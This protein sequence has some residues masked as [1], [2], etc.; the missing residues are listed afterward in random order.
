MKQNKK[1]TMLLIF[2]FGIGLNHLYS[3]EYFEL[4][5]N[6]TENTTLQEIQELAETYFTNR[7]K[8]RGSGYKQYKRWEYKMERYVNAD[9]KIQNFSRLNWDV[10]TKLNSENP[11]VRIAAGDWTNLGPSSYT[12]GSSGYNGGLGRVNVIAFHPTDS[13]IIYVGV[14][15]GGLWKTTDGGTSWSPMSDV[16]ASLGVSGI[17]VDHTTPSTVY[18]LTGDGDGG[19]TKSIGVMKSTDGGGTWTSTGLSWSVTS[20]HKGYKLLMHPTTSSTMFAATTIGLLKTT[21]SWATWTTEISGSFRDIEFKPGD[22]TT[23]Y[24]C[25]K[26]TFYRSTDTGATW[27]LISSGLPTGES[28]AALA[29]SPA[30]SGYVYYLAGPGG[31]SG[32]ST[33]KGMYLSTDSGLTF[34]TKSTTPNILGYDSAGGG[35]SDQSWYDLAIAVNPLDKDNT[36]TGGINIWRSTDGGASNTMIAHW[37]SPTA[38]QYVHADIHELVYNPLDDILYSGSDGGISKSTDNGVTWTNIWDGLEIMQ[39]YRIVGVEDD[40]DLLIGG[41]QD[42]GSNKY[43]GSTTIEHILGGDGMDCMINYLDHD[44]IY[45]SFQLGGLQ[46]STDGG[47]SSTGIQPSGSTGAW[48]TPYAMDASDPTIIYGGYDDVYRSTNMGTSWSNLGSDGSGALAVGIDDPARI[49]AATGSTIATSAD[50]GG[51]WS[52]ITGTWPALTITFIALDPAD[53]KRIWITLGGYTSG[54]KV[55]E[56][57]DAGVSWTNV[58]G[59]LPN[60]PALSIAY[61]DTGGTPMDAMYVGMGVGIYYKSDSTAWTLYNT[62]LPNVPIYDLQINYDNC[63]I[64][65]GTFGRG[66]WE[67]LLYGSVLISD[68]TSTDPSCPGTS[69]ATITVTASCTTCSGISYT[70]TPT[71][72]PGTPITQIGDGVFL[73]LPSNDYDVSVVDTGVASCVNSWASNPIVIAPG[74][75]TTPPTALC[76]GITVELDASGTVT[77]TAGDIDDGSSDNCGIDTMT[78]SPDTFDCSDV[79]TPVSVTL[80][81]TDESGNTDTCIALVTVEDNIDPTAVCLDITV[82]LDASGDASI[83]AGDIDLGSTDNC[84]IDTMSVSPDTFDCSDV[85]TPVTVTLTVTD[86]SG[87]TDSCTATVTVEDNLEPELICPAD[88]TETV[89]EGELFTI[90]D[91]ISGTTATDNCTASPIITQDPVAGTMVGAGLTIITMSA[92]D[93]EG[94]TGTCT[95]TLTVDE[96]LGLENSEINKNIFLYPNPTKGQ[97][98]LVNKTSDRLLSAT[99]IEVNGREIEKL[100][101]FDGGIETILFFDEYASGLYFVIIDTETTSIVKR[102]VKL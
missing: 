10:S 97:I 74:A 64:R 72:P 57:T 19:Q 27:T 41:T 61:Q 50:T 38:T 91:Y 56:S 84:G 42:N 12:N 47:V 13:D 20:F 86:D 94:N 30:D 88:I 5:H 51:S 6:P 46:R 75:D 31:A 1:I 33:Y 23:V 69:D 101:L 70:I 68:V 95:F 63:K 83:T 90:P 66:L 40:Q 80:T 60:S 77:I 65:A 99:I 92:T 39:F 29:V 79:G 71:S 8:G 58:T 9:G 35:T 25:K 36:I 49:Y 102:I 87:N 28:R 85:G 17:A 45:Y 76:L 93:D 32:A 55:Y 22:P 48:V 43:T 2:F 24:A 96:I 78:V 7:D 3:Q 18:I 81:V 52:T 37:Y 14:P 100:D 11:P 54:H 59:S 16:L 4:I 82:E 73:G 62:G 67:A 26:D 53:A 34:S 44:N 15:A 21:D 89:D 98:T